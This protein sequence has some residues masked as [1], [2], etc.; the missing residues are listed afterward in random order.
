[1]TAE[2][3]L[4]SKIK[5]DLSIAEP[6]MYRIIFINDD[7]TPMDFVVESLIQYFDYTEE[8]AATIMIDVHENGSA[9][10]AV[11]PYEI[12]EQ[13][14]VEIT[15]AARVRGYPLQIRVERDT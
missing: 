6:P 8:T 5:P 11:L 15:L 14:G 12:A 13:T 1:M 10:V 9:V 7:Q 3:K 4:T 2:P